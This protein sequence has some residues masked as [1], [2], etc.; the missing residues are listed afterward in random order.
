LFQE[1]IFCSDALYG[2]QN[3]TREEFLQPQLQTIGGT[4]LKIDESFRITNLTQTRRSTMA[5]P[6]QHSSNSKSDKPY[7]SLLTI[8]NK[9]KPSSVSSA[10]H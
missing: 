4:I 9:R 8:F 5:P 2:H 3:I 7:T 10:P 1:R 6:S